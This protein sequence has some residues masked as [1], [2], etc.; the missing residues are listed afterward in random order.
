MGGGK[1]PRGEARA[2]GNRFIVFKINAVPHGIL[3]RTGN[4]SET[5]FAVFN[6]DKVGERRQ[7]P[8]PAPIVTSALVGS[9]HR[10]VSRR[11]AEIW[12]ATEQRAGDGLT[13]CVPH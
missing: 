3:P 6:Q 1:T 5:A 11:V 7:I 8:L 13:N 10:C 4:G 12:D 2:L 9:V